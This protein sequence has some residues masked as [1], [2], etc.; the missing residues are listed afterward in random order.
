MGERREI[1]SS[2][3]AA[4]QQQACIEWA[5]A[6]GYVK[7]MDLAKSLWTNDPTE[8]YLRT[9]AAKH[10]DW[11]PLDVL[12]AVLDALLAQQAAIDR[13]DTE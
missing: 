11:R 4:I 2:D 9:M 12:R 5:E 10:P 6:N 8:T 7:R 13:E 3:L 1:T